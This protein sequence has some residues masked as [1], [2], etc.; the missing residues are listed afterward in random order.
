MAEFK[1]N[2][3]ESL[4]EQSKEQDAKRSSETVIKEAT[5]WLN[6]TI[7]FGKYKGKNVSYAQIFLSDRSYFLFLVR[8]ARGFNLA[9]AYVYDYIL[10]E[11][12]PT[13]VP[14]RASPKK[15]DKKT[16]ESTPASTLN[17]EHR[18]ETVPVKP[19]EVSQPEMEDGEVAEEEEQQEPPAKKRAKR[20]R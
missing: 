20:Q 10:S 4:R 12:F 14:K 17:D 2:L 13:G 11:L 19:E 15:A 16:E 8:Q 5:D 9:K 6:Q 3:F 1:G 18:S 7:N